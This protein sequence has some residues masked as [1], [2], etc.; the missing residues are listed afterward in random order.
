MVHISSLMMHLYINFHYIAYIISQIKKQISILNFELVETTILR[1]RL[2]T[3][4][5]LRILK[6]T[7]SGS[8]I[9]T[10]FSW[11]VNQ[12]LIIKANTSQVMD[13]NIMVTYPV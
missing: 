8:K 9:H 6:W 5:P 12:T 7:S 13:E 4:V 2:A 3:K 10:V 1:Y 11:G